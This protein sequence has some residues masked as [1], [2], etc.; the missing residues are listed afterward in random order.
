MPVQDS[1][2]Q[3]GLIASMDPSAFGVAS[4]EASQ[5]ISSLIVLQTK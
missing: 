1:D 5:A 2:D 4:R 3:G